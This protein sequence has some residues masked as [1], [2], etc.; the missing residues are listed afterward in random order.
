MTAPLAAALLTLTAGVQNAGEPSAAAGAAAADPLCG[1][2]CL[3]VGLR[4]LDEEVT[5]DGLRDALGEPPAGGYVLGELA[6]A[7]SDRGL[8]ARPVA[9]D[10]DWLRTRAGP[11]ACVAHVRGSHFVLITDVTGD[12]VAYIDVP[13]RRSAPAPTFETIWDGNALV[14]ARS[15]AAL[16]DAA[17]PWSTVLLW[18]AGAIAVA[19]AGWWALRRRSAAAAVLAAVLP[20]G[21][22]AGCETGDATGPA[23]VVSPAAAGRP[24]V[25]PR[26]EADL[27]EI[28]LGPEPVAVRFRLLNRGAEPV[29]LGALSTSCRC[30]AAQVSRSTIA[31]GGEA[32]L[33]AEVHP[34]EAG[35]GTASVTV[36]L[37]EPGPMTER[38]TIRWRATAPLSFDPPA[39]EFGPVRPGRTAERRA[40]VAA[41]DGS[42]GTVA[43]IDPPRTAGLTARFEGG[44]VIVAVQPG[45]RIGRVRE[46]LRVRFDGGEV[47]AL[48]VRWEVAP[49][50]RLSPPALFL[51]PAVAPGAGDDSATLSGTAAV[52]SAYGA[53]EV[54]G[55]AVE[56]LPWARAEVLPAAGDRAVLVRV[57]GTPPAGVGEFPAGTLRVDVSA[58]VRRTLTAAV[59][60][61][62]APP[63]DRL[64][65]VAP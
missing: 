22:L 40:R 2:H 10:L 60:A 23:A 36:R 27:G 17:P 61:R 53:P 12:G 16:E 3:Y 32:F 13:H 45:D 26:R 59:T 52:V 33:T 35:E 25:I 5:L 37:S 55:A 6:Q 28:P 42:G 1:L 48:P 21:P 43:G 54:T 11:L 24:L 9:A 57:S 31:P 38:V 8:V 64:S 47:V 50:V 14:L 46:S 41:L 63:A 30:T 51:G 34:A 39:V 7:A 20:L 58:P 15:E 65:G 62:I 56:G 49:A 29:R 19:A 44:E 18:A 4:T